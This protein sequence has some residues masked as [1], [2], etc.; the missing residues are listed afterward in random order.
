MSRVQREHVYPKKSRR[1]KCK[2]NSNIT[3]FTT[4]AATYNHRPRRIGLS[5]QTIKI[6]V[7]DCRD[8][9]PEFEE[10]IKI[11]GHNKEMKEVFALFHEGIL[12]SYAIAPKIF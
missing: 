3:L 4:Q 11:F 7:L 8:L 9:L 2:I 5:R 12:G 10:L 1:P 6:Q